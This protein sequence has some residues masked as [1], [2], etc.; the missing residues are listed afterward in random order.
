MGQ[1]G[2]YTTLKNTKPCWI[3]GRCRVGSS[4]VFQIAT[5]SGLVLIL[6]RKDYQIQGKHMLGSANYNM[7]NTFA[8]YTGSLKF[9][10][11]KVFTNSSPAIIDF[12]TFWP[13]AMGK[14]NLYRSLPS[15]LLLDNSVFSL[16]DIS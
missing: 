1:A 10:F 5:P 8:F 12:I 6:Q 11:I 14:K 7:M 2:G 16:T 9:N 15:F 3:C 4:S 13:F